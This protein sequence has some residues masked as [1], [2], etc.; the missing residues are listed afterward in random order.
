MEHVHAFT[1]VTADSKRLKRKIIII[2]IKKLIYTGLLVVRACS[3]WLK[4]CIN[5]GT[6]RW[7]ISYCCNSDCQ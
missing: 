4:L 3:F 1:N 2:I 7:K 6:R 5:G